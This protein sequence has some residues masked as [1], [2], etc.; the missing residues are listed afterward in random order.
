MDSGEAATSHQTLLLAHTSVDS[1]SPHTHKQ[2]QI[3][4]SAQL[5]TIVVFI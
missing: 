2:L 5:Y 3:Q 4:N 1:Q